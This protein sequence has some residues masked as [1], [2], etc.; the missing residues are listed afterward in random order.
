M[1]EDID[2]LHC[3]YYFVWPQYPTKIRPIL[4]LKEDQNQTTFAQKR[5]PYVGPTLRLDKKLENTGEN[6]L[7]LPNN[8]QIFRLASLA[9]EKVDF[10]LEY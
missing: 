4:Y 8:L 6:T 10:F 1:E 5:R 3:P 2:M 9:A 7:K